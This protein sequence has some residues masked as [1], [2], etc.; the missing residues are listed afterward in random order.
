MKGE[1]KQSRKGSDETK[2]GRTETVRSIER[3]GG[4]SKGTHSFPIPNHPDHSKVSGPGG[5]MDH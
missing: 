3:V 4:H 5:K 2:P 1:N